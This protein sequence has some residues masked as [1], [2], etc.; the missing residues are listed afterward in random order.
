MGAPCR[1][2]SGGGGGASARYG[3]RVFHNAATAASADGYAR[4]GPQRAPATIL[5]G[6]TQASGG[7]CRD[8]SR[9]GRGCGGA[10]AGSGDEGRSCPLP[11]V[12]ASLCATSCSRV[13]R[14]AAAQRARAVAACARRDGSPSRTLC[15]DGRGY[16]PPRAHV[17]RCGQLSHSAA[18]RDGRV[19]GARGHAHQCATTARSSGDPRAP[20]PAGASG[21]RHQ[22]P[23]ALDRPGRIFV[24]VCVCHGLSGRRHRLAHQRVCVWAARD[25]PAARC[26]GGGRRAA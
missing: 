25:R 16:I 22:Q 26:P 17:S 6:V 11:R 21:G 12:A 7:A 13:C 24:C 23:G 14:P 18:R 9:S 1:R 5:L 8:H 2:L 15:F 3:R 4:R 10:G 20:A 19:C